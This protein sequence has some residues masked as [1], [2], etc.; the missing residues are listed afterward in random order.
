MMASKG[1]PSKTEEK[2]NAL[3][4][5]IKKY[6]THQLSCVRLKDELAGVEQSRLSDCTCGFFK[7]YENLSKVF[8]RSS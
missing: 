2:Q 1:A 5:F 8:G 3:F 6:C 4:G 7:A